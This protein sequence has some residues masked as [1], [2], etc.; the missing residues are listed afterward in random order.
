M[1]SNP[2]AA[3]HELCWHLDT[4][5]TIDLKDDPCVIV[6]QESAPF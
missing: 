3:D 4:D 1:S 5:H 2:L 6:I